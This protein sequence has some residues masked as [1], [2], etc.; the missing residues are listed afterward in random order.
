MSKVTIILP[1]YNN[2]EDLSKAIQ[3]VVKQT[4]TN[5]EL[6]IINDA[7]TDNI[8]DVLKKYEGNSKIR[9]ITNDINRGCYWCLNY[10]IQNS[11]GKYIT[12]IDSDDTYHQRK[13]KYQVKFLDNHL[14]FLGIFVAAQN[15]KGPAVHP[16]SMAAFM[17]R[18]SIIGKVGYYDSV[19][20]SADLEYK[21][22]LF[23]YFG[24]R[25]FKISSNIMYYIK[26]R[27]NSLTKNK[28][29][30]LRSAARIHYNSTFRKWHIRNRYKKDN[31]YL[32]FP[33]NNR[34]L[35]LCLSLK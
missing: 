24:K 27:K 16:T 8:S 32:S 4:Y 9:I 2:C 23:L 20:F 6:I 28:N 26:K 34:L 35:L 22:R 13:L 11:D 14:K 3:S 1:V 33:L 19:R 29:T 25:Q 7:S 31:L 18:R 12:R 21:E 5:W 17:M 30:N 15:I 10:A